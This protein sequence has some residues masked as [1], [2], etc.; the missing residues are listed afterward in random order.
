[1]SGIDPRI[2]VARTFVALCDGPDSPPIEAAVMAWLIME[3]GPS[4]TITRNNPW[5]LHSSG[6][7]PGQIGT[8]YVGPGDT[9]VAVFSTVQAGVA[10]CVANL[11]AHGS[12][13]AGYD[14]VLA[15]VKKGDALG[16]LDALARSSWSAGRYGGP[17]ASNQLIAVYN[18]LTAG[19]PAAGIAGGGMPINTSGYNVTSSKVA[20]VK[21]PSSIREAPGGSVIGQLTKV[22]ARYTALGI[23]SGFIACLVPNASIWP[24]KQTR[25]TVL[26][27]AQETVTLEDAPA[28]TSPDA[29]THT[30]TVLV[31]GATKFSGQF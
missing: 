30:V 2:L 26:F 17:G 27:V 20:I 11:R 1:M 6:G 25:P 19:T 21:N 5:N 23:D 7:L 3:N 10:A 24:D 16:F 8:V 15:A 18:R 29:G 14:H 28:T 31:D 9:N 22:G 4:P 13:Y 12:D